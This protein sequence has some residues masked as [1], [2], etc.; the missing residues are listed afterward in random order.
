MLTDV[1]DLL[2]GV[3]YYSSQERRHAEA[4]FRA[5]FG[6]GPEYTPSERRALRSEFF[7]YTGITPR[8]FPWTEWR[9]GLGY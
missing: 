1:W 3:Q 9:E 4:L 7:D 6:T 2:P 5:S 8:F